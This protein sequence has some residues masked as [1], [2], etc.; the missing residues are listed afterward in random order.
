MKRFFYVTA[1]VLGLSMPSAA[2]AHHAMGGAPMQ[3]FADGLLSGIGHPLL[4]FD[5][6]LFV[7]LVGIAA[8]FTGKRFTAPAAYIAAMLAGCLA[9]SAGV[10]LPAKEIVIGLSLLVLGVIVLSGTTLRLVPALAAFA[11]FGLFHGSAFGDT[12]AG[13]EA[14]AGSQVLVGYLIGLGV[15]Q[16]AIALASG[17]FA[18]NVLRVA[19]AASVEARLAGAVVAGAGLL[20]T[21]ENAEDIVFSLLGW[22]T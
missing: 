19:N 16:Y 7:A 8:I 11:T 6:M 20:L 4:G 2:F 3:T 12:M 17:W 1:A 14:A 10:G 9:M 15:V 13:Q 5:H 21:L 18:A 22:A